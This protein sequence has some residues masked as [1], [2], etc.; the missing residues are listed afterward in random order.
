M[1]NEIEKAILL[2]TEDILRTDLFASSNNS[3]D[4][5]L[6]EKL[7]LDWDEYL[8]HRQNVNSKLDS[9]YVK[10]LIDSADSNIQKASK[11]G[12]LPRSQVYRLLKRTEKSE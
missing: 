11:L 8:S 2:S 7:P 3:A 4:S 5:S 12:N 6:F 1:E 9:N 10:A